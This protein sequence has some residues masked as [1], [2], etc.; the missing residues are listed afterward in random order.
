MPHSDNIGANTCFDT[1]ISQK[2]PHNGQAP[3][4]EIDSRKNELL[5]LGIID[6][7]SSPIRM[8][9]NNVLIILF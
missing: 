6:S 8:L 1:K 5:Y 3:I 4:C 9:L 7:F 2:F